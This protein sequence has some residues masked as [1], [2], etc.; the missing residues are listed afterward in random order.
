MVIVFTLLILSVI[1]V[2]GCTDAPNAISSCVSTRS[3][4]PSASIALAAFCNFLGSTLTA[5]VNTKV[6]STVYSTVR[7]PQDAKTSLAALIAGM[8]AVVIWAV[9]AWFFGI[10]TSESHALLSGLSGAVFAASLSPNS[11]VFSEWLLVFAGL[12]LSTLPSLIA[13][14][15]IYSVILK[16]CAKHDRRRT[17]R[18]FMRTQRLSAAWSAFSHGAQDSQ[19]FMGVFMLGMSINLGEFTKESFDIPWYVVICCSAVMTLGTLIGGRRII[20]KVGMDMVDIDA[21]GGTAADMASSAVLFLCTLFGIP[22]STT[23]SKTSAMIGVGTKSGKGADKRIVA[24]MLFAWILTFPICALIGFLLS[25]L[26]LQ[27]I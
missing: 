12:I 18:Y 21:V 16:L 26:I 2:N 11:I 15:L 1:L 19:K 4:S 10:P 6:A 27:L 24:Q 5:L 14:R 20:K 3:L 13:A 25:F 9:A 7:L 22:V 17:I 23:H 8:G